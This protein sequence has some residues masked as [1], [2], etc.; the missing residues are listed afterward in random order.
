MK[1][2]SLEDEIQFLRSLKYLDL[3]KYL[4]DKYG[5][6][7]GD[8][9]VSES[10]ATPNL[11]IKRSNEGLFIHHIKECEFPDLSKKEMA[12]LMPYEYQ[13]AN[14]LVYCNYFEH[15]LL[16]I[17][18]VL[19]YMTKEFI[20]IYPNLK[21]PGVVV[22]GMGGLVNFILPEIVDYINGYQY[23]KS[24]LINALKIIDGREYLFVEIVKDF[25]NELRKPKHGSKYLTGGFI[26]KRKFHASFFEGKMTR[27]G[28]IKSLLKEF[29]QEG[30]KKWNYYRVIKQKVSS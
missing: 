12:L 5:I 22:V 16:H 30:V 26:Q 21:K 13:K 23:Q 10:C 9:F 18:I 2:S 14:N 24:H 25:E 17:D 19:E 1:Y 20:G 7:Q 15:L 29:D 28:R 4:Q 11:K 8:Y 6:P 3:C 27:N